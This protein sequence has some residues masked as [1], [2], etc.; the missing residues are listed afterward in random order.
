MKKNNKSGPSLLRQKAEELLKRRSLKTGSALSETEKLKLIHELEVYQIELELQNEELMLAK[1][2]S[3]I[4]TEKYTELYDFAPSGYFT[5]SSDGKIIELNLVGANILGK[6]RSILR[7]SQFGFFVSNDTKSIFNLFL[8]NIFDSKVKEYCEVTL[9]MKNNNQVHVHLTGIAAENGEQCLVTVIDITQRK[10]MEEELI[11]AKEKAEESDLLKTAFLQNMSHEIRTPI[12]TIMGF[13]GLLTEQYNNKPKLE[14][15]SN[16]IIQRSND[17]LDII[18]D[19]LSIAKIGSGQL[20]VNMEE[21]HLSDLFTELTTFFEEYQKRNSKQ[22]IQFNLHALCDQSEI[23]IVTDKGK[24]KQ[25]FI[26]LINNAF[27]YTNAGKIEGGCKLDNNNNLIFYVSDTGI[28]IPSEKQKL[29]FER[30]TQLNQ[31]IDLTSGG[32]GLG[33]S[34]VKG[35][36]CLLGGEIFLESEPGKG[37]K[38]TFAF[39]YKKIQE[40]HHES[41]II[42]EPEEFNF[43]DKK[44]LLVEDDL[45][46]VKY[47]KEILKNTGLHIIHTI[48]GKDAIKISLTQR[49]DMVLM[50]IRLPDIDGYEATRQIKNHKPD[51]KIIAQTAYASIEDKQKASDAGCND[52]ISKPI[53]HALLKELMQKHLNN[54]GQNLKYSKKLN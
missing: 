1:K 11:K 23:L 28:G 25:I 6:E 26:N 31:G 35:L 34:I 9:Q 44:I 14:Q 2:Q 48:S 42:K 22:H 36:V 18:D 20:S 49:L 33:L 54:S 41:L 37:S 10:M 17:L 30:F 46:N 19:I 8:R 5:L 13:S 43:S 29:I 12:N 40:L 32:I 16:I 38:F 50:D 45:Y 39:P 7:K 4:T 51:L 3:D 21:C 15:F 47:L 24:L 53:N 27:K 52:Y